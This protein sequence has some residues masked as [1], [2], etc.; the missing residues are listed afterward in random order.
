MA[1]VNVNM[2]TME[3]EMS[4]VKVS[5]LWFIIQIDKERIQI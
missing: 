3:M 4:D 1:S 5:L 2:V